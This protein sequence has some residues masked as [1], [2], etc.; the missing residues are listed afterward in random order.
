MDFSPFQFFTPN[1]IED[2]KVMVIFV[3]RPPSIEMLFLGNRK[4]TTSKML[5]D[6]ELMSWCL[7]QDELGLNR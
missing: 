7:V 3:T 4:R 2:N 6:D 1:R 5:V